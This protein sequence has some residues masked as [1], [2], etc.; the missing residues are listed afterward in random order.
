[1]ELFVDVRHGY[2]PADGSLSSGRW[3]AI[4]ATTPGALLR[5][6]S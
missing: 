6:R 2:P 4:Q 3:L 1:M 5:S